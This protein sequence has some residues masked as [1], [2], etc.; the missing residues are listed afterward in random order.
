M[1]YDFQL[2]CAN[3]ATDPRKTVTLTLT[4]GG[5]LEV[6][7]GER[8]IARLRADSFLVAAA[9]SVAVCVATPSIRAVWDDDGNIPCGRLP[10]FDIR[11]LRFHRNVLATLREGSTDYIGAQAESALTIKCHGEKDAIFAFRHADLAHAVLWLNGL[12]TAEDGA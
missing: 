9:M 2:H 1:G 8:A 3:Y 6:F 10:E 7:D 4:D 12:L 11:T 5:A